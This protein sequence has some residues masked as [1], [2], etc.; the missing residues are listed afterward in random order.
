MPTQ[1][2]AVGKPIAA[3]YGNFGTTGYNEVT[4]LAHAFAG[5]VGEPGTGKTLIHRDNEAALNLN[6]DQHSTPKPAPDAAP[7]KFA[8]Y[9]Q[10]DKT[11]R[12]LDEK[13]NPFIPRMEDYYRKHEQ[14]LIA[15]SANQPRP[16]TIVI[17]TVMAMVPLLQSYYARV[18]YFNGDDTKT[19]D[20][21]PGGKITMSA[22]GKVYD[23]CRNFLFELRNAG[24]GVHMNAHLQTYWVTDTEGNRTPVIFHNIPDKIYD[25][26]SYRL[27]FWGC[28]AR[29]EEKFTDT[30]EKGKIIGT[31]SRTA[32]YLVNLSD[33][34]RDT[35]RARVNLPKE[36]L[37]PSTNIFQHIESEYQKAAGG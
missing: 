6:F 18:R 34:L 7:P 20:D 16:K 33:T 21:I 27:D 31:T 26:I 14:L 37:L 8:V 23:Y 12:S 29:R 35:A 9:P 32:H 1:T 2:L 5:F 15:A 17:D 10:V 4:G 36:I 13:G 24:Y 11:G 25:R 3:E 30:D 19:W 28:I 22:Y